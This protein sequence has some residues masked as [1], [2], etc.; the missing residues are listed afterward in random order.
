VD[1]PVQ[2]AAADSRGA[3]ELGADPEPEPVESWVVQVF[4]QS[5]CPVFPVGFLV[6]PAGCSAYYQVCPLAAELA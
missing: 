1:V 6:A 5:V 2:V 3:P 4:R